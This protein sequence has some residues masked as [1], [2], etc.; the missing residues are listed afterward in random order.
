[1]NYFKLEYGEE[2]EITD[3]QA[4]ALI[5]GSTASSID[6]LDDDL[7][8]VKFPINNVFIQCN[9]QQHYYRIILM[10]NANTRF[11]DNR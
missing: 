5:Q 11:I 3:I 6:I 10:C 2:K 9:W 8:I 4:T 1:M 7:C